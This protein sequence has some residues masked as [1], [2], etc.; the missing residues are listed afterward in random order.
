MSIH[1]YLAD[2]TSEIIRR[3][4]LPLNFTHILYP[5]NGKSEEEIQEFIG[6]LSN[7]RENKVIVTDSLF[8]IREVELAHLPVVWFNFDFA[9]G[10]VRDSNSVD[11]IGNIHIL[12]RELRQSERYINL[13]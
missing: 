11:D 2:R 5:E 4:Y 1:I 8:F 12:D 13:M 3:K 9:S 7:N 6:Q 10:T